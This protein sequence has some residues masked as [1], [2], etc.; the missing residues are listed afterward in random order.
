[1]GSCA[2][3]VSLTGWWRVLLAGLGVSSVGGH[4]GVRVARSL[5]R[6]KM[7][8]KETSGMRALEMWCREAV[9]GYRGVSVTNMTSS[10]R[11]GRALC[12]LIHRYRP[13]LIDFDKLD[14][15]DSI[16]NCKLAFMIAERDL[17]IPCLLDVGDL[18]SYPYPDKLSVITYLSQFYFKLSERDS[19]V[20]S[21]SPASSDGEQEE[22]DKRDKTNKTNDV[23]EKDK[24]NVGAVESL[25]KRRRTRS[26]SLGYN[27]CR[28]EK[29]S[30]SPPIHEENPFIGML[31]KDVEKQV[32]VNNLEQEVC[33]KEITA[34]TKDY[35]RSKNH[36]ETR[37]CAKSRNERMT[38]SLILESSCNVLN[39]ENICQRE[40]RRSS[41]L[42]GSLP[43]PYRKK[44]T[45]ERVSLLSET[46]GVFMKERRARSQTKLSRERS[47][48][49]EKPF[50]ES[51][52]K[53]EALKYK[54]SLFINWSY[55]SK[56]S[57]TV[58]AKENRK[59]DLKSIVNNCLV[60]VSNCHQEINVLQANNRE[61]NTLPF[62]QTCV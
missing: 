3:P 20:C 36:E 23:K 29:R 28:K 43:Q 32:L 5:Q 49:N 31:T 13:H 27:F 45:E 57:A 6:G 52:F 15:K 4:G 10:W 50:Q 1:M 34:K 42:I 40:S 8:N 39:E 58:S 53:K 48:D 2:G 18:V 51:Q 33:V 44:K 12:A 47:F 26:A 7:R 55:Q 62:I 54:T 46:N 24:T 11:D 61:P 41:L 60:N 19:G 56:R 16:G 17:G 35:M 38:K 14:P 25:M 21:S 30:I 59:S 37:K 9:R 22:K